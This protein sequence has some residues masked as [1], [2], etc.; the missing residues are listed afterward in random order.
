MVLPSLLTKVW[1][2]FS[3][4]HSAIL[5]YCALCIF[6][7]KKKNFIQ[8][9]SQCCTFT[10]KYAF[11]F[12]FF[13]LIYYPFVYFFVFFFAYK[14]LNPFNIKVRNLNPKK[15]KRK[16]L[17]LLFLSTTAMFVFFCFVTTFFKSTLPPKAET[18]RGEAFRFSRRSQEFC[19][20]KS[21]FPL[22]RKRSLRRCY[23]YIHN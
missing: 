23:Y 22:R 11:R 14:P 20:K 8:Y 4:Y 16:W 3:L 10:S 2:W 15:K 21:V 6:Y 7:F 12:S 13:S 19:I 18:T 1:I 5:I 9:T 17:W